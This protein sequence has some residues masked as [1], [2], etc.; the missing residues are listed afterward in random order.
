MASYARALLALGRVEEA[1]PHAR[2]AMAL[3]EQLGSLLQGATLPPLILAQALD[4]TGHAREARAAMAAAVTRLQRRAAR[5]TNPEWR[6]RFLA[7]L[8]NRR[9]LELARAWGVTSGPS[10]P[11]ASP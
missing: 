5:F 1:L 11:E 3:L 2:E 9:T 4:A 7:L 10:Q 8:E 6:S